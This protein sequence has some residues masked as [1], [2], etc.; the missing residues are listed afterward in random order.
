[1]FASLRPIGAVAAVLPV[2]MSLGCNSISCRLGM[3]QETGLPTQ[4]HAHPLLH[5]ALISSSGHSRHPLDI[6]YP[7]PSP[8][9]EQPPALKPTGD[10]IVWAPGYWMWD[11]NEDNWHWVRGVWVHAPPGRRW[12]PGYWSI[13]A[14][15][16]RWVPGQWA[17]DPP[18]PPPSTP[19]VYAYSPS[20]YNYG[21]AGLAFYGGYGIWWPG[22]GYWP[23]HQ[24]AHGSEIVPPVAH[25]AKPMPVPLASLPSNVHEAPSQPPHLDMESVFASVPK[26]LATELN[27]HVPFEL[28]TAHPL[29]AL[30]AGSYAPS[31]RISSLFS[32]VAHMEAAHSFSSEM[33][34]ASSSHAGGGHGGGGGHGR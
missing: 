15:G 12:I 17:I 1:M 29:F 18:P 22:Y 14:D 28:H 19:P 32:N 26:P 5:E 16:W 8:L 13:V 10:D 2:L 34:H 20:G 7:P 6:L 33:G 4:V 23:Y 9:S 3:H 27:P 25:R 11:T 24:A 31:E 21:N 30:H